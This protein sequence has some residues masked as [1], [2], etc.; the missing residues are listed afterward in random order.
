VR[1]DG[2]G[3]LLR[4]YSNVFFYPMTPGQTVA[5][6]L[7]GEPCALPAADEEQGEAIAWVPGS[8]DYV[9]ISEGANAT[10]NRVSCQA[11]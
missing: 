9:S 3:V 2:L 8:W 6:A 7:R 10:I 11:P 5:E 4:T 1:P